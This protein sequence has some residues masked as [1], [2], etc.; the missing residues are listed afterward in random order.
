MMNL[1]TLKEG[2][3]YKKIVQDLWNR[4][5]HIIKHKLRFVIVVGAVENVDEDEKKRQTP[6][7]GMTIHASLWMLG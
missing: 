5:K 1:P 4:F 3:R 7:C 2:D 6:T